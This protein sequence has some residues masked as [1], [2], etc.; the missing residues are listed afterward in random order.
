MEKERESKQDLHMVFIDLE[1]AFDRVPRDIIWQSFRAQNVPEWLV[2]LVMDM[3]REVKTKV[4]SP[5]DLSDQFDLEV[6]VHQADLQ[7]KPPWNILYAD[8]IALI[9]EDV[10]E[11]QTTLEQWRSTLENAGLRVS[12]QKTVYMHCS[13]SNSTHGT[14]QLQNTPLKRVEFFKYLGSILTSDGTIELDVSNRINTGWMKWRELTGVLCNS[15]MPIPLK[16]KS[17]KLQ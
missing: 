5:A 12:R 6:G 10:E 4:R 11:L 1:K 17:T 2:Q 13:F 3:Y 16:A 8:D 15:K 7:K 14:I 9:S